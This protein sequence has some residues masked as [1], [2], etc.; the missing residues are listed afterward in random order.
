MAT[1]PFSETR[2][3][4]I[5]R[6]CPGLIARS[7]QNGIAVV[8]ATMRSR[9]RGSRAPTR[10]RSSR[11]GLSRLGRLFSILAAPFTGRPAMA[12]TAACRVRSRMRRRGSKRETPDLFSHPAASAL[13]PITPGSALTAP[14]L[15]PG[16]VE[17]SLARLS[18]ADF[19]RLRAA[20]SKE[21]VRRGGPAPEPPQRAS[22]QAER[23]TRSAIR[24]KVEADEGRA[25][26]QAVTAARGNAIRAAFRAGLKPPAIAR[27]FGVSQATVREVL[28]TERKP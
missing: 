8:H 4:S 2:Q 19:E 17:G 7:C 9:S 23:G 18:E 22:A 3:V 16:D 24:V 21:A 11:S 28:Q 25:R 14:V 1:A 12:A 5:E 15:L 13:T 26:A 6:R 20:V 27:Q 10:A